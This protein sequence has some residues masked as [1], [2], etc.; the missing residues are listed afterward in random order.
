MK[1]LQHRDWG[2]NKYENI[3]TTNETKEI[4]KLT[5]HQEDETF[6]A[7]HESL[8]EQILFL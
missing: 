5:K 2:A 7:R 1:Q 3:T 4:S 6:T 8:K